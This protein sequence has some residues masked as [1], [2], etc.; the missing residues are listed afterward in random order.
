M[1]CSALGRA[2]PATYRATQLP[3]LSTASSLPSLFPDTA[4]I[5]VDNNASCVAYRDTAR[6]LVDNAASCVAIATNAVR[7]AGPRWGS[8]SELLHPA[9][10]RTA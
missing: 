7:R 1:T 9:G 4:R 10:V 3:S 6:I 5:L 8:V 2:R